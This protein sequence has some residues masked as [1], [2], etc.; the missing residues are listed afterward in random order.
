[1]EVKYHHQPCKSEYL[2]KWRSSIKVSQTISP[3]K[4]AG[5]IVKK[6]IIEFIE[7]YI[8]MH[9]KSVYL[10]DALDSYEKL[11]V[12]NGGQEDKS[13]SYTVKNLSIF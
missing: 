13:K 10:S 12:T 2:N 3:D 5:K 4:R 9:G 1:M 6:K 11:S 8:I 7:D